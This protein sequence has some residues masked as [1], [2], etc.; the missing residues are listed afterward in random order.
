MGNSGS[1]GVTRVHRKFF[2]KMNVKKCLACIWNSPIGHLSDMILGHIHWSGG[3]NYL[4]DIVF[5]SPFGF[6]IGS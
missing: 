4:I 3:T 1:L 6:V 5:A 2:S